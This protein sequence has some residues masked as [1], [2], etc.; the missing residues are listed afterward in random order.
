M[1]VAIYGGSFNPPHVA[2]QMAALYVL[3]TAPVDELWLVPAVRHA[4]GKAL[5]P[6]ADRLAMCERAAAALGPRVRVSAIEHE[7][8]QESR[9]LRTIRRLQQDHPGHSFSL[10][11]GADLL[12]EVPSWQGGEE[13][14]RTVPFIVVGRAGFAAESPVALPAVSSR[15]VR[16]A[17]AAGQDVSALVPR[18]V[19]DY[20]SAHNLYKAGEELA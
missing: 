3:E 19:L 6:F 18:A 16:A 1:R 5:A 11:I 20:I 13:L 14:Q 12:D 4:F 7:L 10:V 15:Q 2:H 9:T 8:G 17:L